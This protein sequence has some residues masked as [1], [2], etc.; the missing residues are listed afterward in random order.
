L[1]TIYS[2]NIKANYKLLK[3]AMEVLA[4]IQSKE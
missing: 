4:M 2:F 1:Y 3:Y